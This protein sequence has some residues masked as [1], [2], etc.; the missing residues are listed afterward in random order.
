VTSTRVMTEEKPADEAEGDRGTEPDD[1][2]EEDGGA[3]VGGA[4]APLPEGEQGE[5]GVDKQEHSE[6]DG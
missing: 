4:E 6:P 5:R 3:S 1:D 2:A